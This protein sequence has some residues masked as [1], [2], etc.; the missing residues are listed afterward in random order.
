MIALIRRH[1]RPGWG[2][3]LLACLAA[4]AL[5]AGCGGGG[6]GGGTTGGTT[7]GGGNSTVTLTGVLADKTTGILL[8]NRTVV[9]QG[10]A[11]AGVTNAQGQFSI[12]GVPATAVTLV[13]TDSIGSLDGAL[14]VNVAKLS[15]G[16][17]RSA[18]TLTLDLS[19]LPPP[20]PIV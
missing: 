6:G 15:G 13:V 18:G 17:T 3:V 7:G 1:G 14:P 20:P 2:S 10:T 12:A 5:L 19:S 8:G 9:V 4:M 16:G 11:L